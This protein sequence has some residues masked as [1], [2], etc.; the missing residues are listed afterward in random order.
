MPR[1][2]RIVP[3][4]LLSTLQLSACGTK[5]PRPAFD[6]AQRTQIADS[7]KSRVRAAYELTGGS[8]VERFLSLYPRSGRVVSAT[9]G[10]I[11]ESRDSLASAIDAFWTGVGQFMIDPTWTWTQ[12]EFDVVTAD[13]AIMTSQYVVPH[14]T[15]RGNAHVIGGVWTAVWQRGSQGWAI[16]H[17]H[18]SDL[19]RAAAEQ[20]EARMTPRDSAGT[21]SAG[22]AGH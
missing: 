8:P 6:D 19:P 16:T 17:E 3:I 11:T 2:A 10:R 14:H 9:A 21:D 5:A 4:V 12:L 18:L 20:L 7:L 13:L 1:A 15:D 22:H